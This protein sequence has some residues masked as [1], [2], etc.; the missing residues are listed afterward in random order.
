MFRDEAIIEVRGGKGGDGLS[1]FRREKYIPK[2]GP[3][4]GDGGRGGSVLLF[5]DPNI[6]TLLDFKHKKVWKA[7]R[8]EHG[9]GKSM[10]GASADDVVLKAPPGTL[11]YDRNTDE[12][13]V[14][15]GPG[16]EFVIA[17]G[18]HDDLADLVA[19]F[20]LAISVL[21][22]VERKH[23]VDNRGIASVA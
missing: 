22:L 9:K 10:Y 12:L 2:G 20:H 14:D 5:G 3:D 4:G 7:S 8:G 11:V 18:L 15:L 6:N 16:E 13:I 23:A 17:K 19:A 1:S 21:N